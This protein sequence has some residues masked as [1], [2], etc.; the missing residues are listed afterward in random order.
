MIIVK[1]HHVCDGCQTEFGLEP[2]GVCLTGE[3]CGPCTGY[4]RLPC[5]GKPMTEGVYLRVCSYCL[6]RLGGLAPLP[7]AR[8]DIR[9]YCPNEVIAV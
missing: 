9:I 8:N 1:E 2:C 7:D 6:K 4:L 3:W 5:K